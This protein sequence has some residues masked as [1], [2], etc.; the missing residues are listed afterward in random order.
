[1][2]TEWLTQ[3]RLKLNALLRRKQLD[4]DLDDELAFHLEMRKEKL[5]T[6]GKEFK[7]AHF[8]ALRQFG[9]ATSLKEKTRGMW[10]FS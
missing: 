3:A 5:R 2:F 1:M 9:N 4:R 10:A 8:E 7:E 6:T